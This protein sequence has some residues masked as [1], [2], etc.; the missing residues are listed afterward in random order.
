MG[1]KKSRSAPPPAPPRPREEPFHRPFRD[2]CEQLRA[3]GST[4]PAAP[5][6]AAPPA[7]APAAPPLLPAPS[8]KALMQ[9]EKAV[10]LAEMA[11]V[12][13]LPKDPRGRVEKPQLT[14]KSLY[15]T[16]D[17]E[18]L[19]DLR[20]LVAGRGEFTIQY[21][22]EYMEGLA[23][24]VDRRLAQRLHRGDYAV[25]AHIDLHGHTVE[26]A[27]VA[28]ERFVTDAYAAGQRCIL[29]IHG[30]GLNSKDN[31]PVL[32]EQ[33]RHWLSHGR[34]SRLVLAFATAPLTNGGAGAVYV[35]LRRA[36][37]FQKK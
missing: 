22:D 8:P 35:L 32:K 15:P 26:E 1:R 13:P 24:G 27:K 9:R 34:L 20:A 18:A 4:Q 37:G 11:G 21:T 16:D 36:P 19:A 31:R 10:F 29:L 23:P 12:A 17:Y 2:M 6:A 14:P 30:R 28:V 5:P 7:A 25:Q 3:I 33:V